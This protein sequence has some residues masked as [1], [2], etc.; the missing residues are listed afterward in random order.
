MR[1]M[2]SA[3]LGVAAASMW[4]IQAEAQS[5]WYVE[6][7]VGGYFRDAQSSSEAF[8]HEATPTTTVPG[9]IKQTFSPGIIG[10]IGLGYRVS[11]HIRLE[12]EVGYFGYDT[13]A[14]NPSTA[15]A[16][17][18]ELNGQTYTR[19]SGAEWSRY[20]G[21]VNAFYDFSPIAK[22]FTPYVGGGVGASADHR[23]TGLFTNAT[24]Q[25][26]SGSPGGSSSE[27][28][29]F[30]EAGV[31]IAIA[32]HWAIVPSYRYVR[33]FSANEDVASVAKVGL[34]YSF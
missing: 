20:S 33:F 27:G 6:G 30:L 9:T 3:M 1:F 32:P 14:V 34:R 31:A 21:T 22:R 5:P 25:T 18:P 29:G 28:L 10:D 12:A 2:M 24:G 17:F 15:A 4:T 23:T 13:H 19:Q 11:P 8:F 16:G 7:S 26:F